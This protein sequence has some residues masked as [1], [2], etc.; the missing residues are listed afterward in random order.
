MLNSK[1][2]KSLLKLFLILLGLIIFTSALGGGIQVSEN[3]WEDIEKEENSEEEF[4]ENSQENSSSSE[5]NSNS[6]TDKNVKELTKEVNE[7]K[8]G[9]EELEIK[10]KVKESIEPFQGSVFAGTF[11]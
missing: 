11:W 2:N 9:V 3:F 10:D 4:S 5:N 7:P 8:K 6:E 1:Y